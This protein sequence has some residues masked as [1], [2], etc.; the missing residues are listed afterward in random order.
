MALSC[1]IFLLYPGSNKSRV[2]PEVVG[3]WDTGDWTIV[4][5]AMMDI[6]GILPGNQGT[7]LDMGVGE[8]MDI[9]AADQNIVDFSLPAA[10]GI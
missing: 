1:M 5:L 2:S 9:V 7:A 8:M 10:V 6:V 4:D 3:N